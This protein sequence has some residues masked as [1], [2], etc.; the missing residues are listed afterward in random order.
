M[1]KLHLDVDMLR[2]E[3]FDTG[4]AVRGGTVHGLSGEPSHPEICTPPITDDPGAYSCGGATCAASCA[5]CGS[6]GCGTFG[7]NTLAGPT[8]T[9]RYLSCL[10]QCVTD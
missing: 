2:V 8:C 3:T 10:N 6:A 4:D 1:K 5:G 9:P 7:C